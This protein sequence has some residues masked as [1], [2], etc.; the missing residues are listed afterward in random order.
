MRN[1]TNAT[2]F[3]SRTECRAACNEGEFAAGHIDQQTGETYWIVQVGETVHR[4]TAPVR[5]ERHV[6][7]PSGKRNSSKALCG[8]VFAK[9]GAD[10]DAF[11]AGAIALG[12]KA[13]TARTMFSHY[14]VGR[15]ASA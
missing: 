9:V 8:R 1:S 10:K 5:S 13:T 7:T 14:T 6:Y 11:L 4:N 15:Y 2:R 3:A 12:V